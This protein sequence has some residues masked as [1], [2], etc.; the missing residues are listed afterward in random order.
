MKKHFITG[1][2]IL[3]PGV[4]TLLVLL[5]LIDFLTKPFIGFATDCFIRWDLIPHGFGFFTQQQIIEYL[6]RILIL[7][8][9]FAATILLGA[10]A[11]W[12]FMHWVIK[13]CD[14][15]LLKIPLVSTIYKATQDIIKTLF[16]SDKN[17][18]KQ[19]VMVPF[20]RPGVYVLGLV[21]RE[22]PM[23]C[24]EATKENLIS[25]LVPTTPNPTTGFLLMF[26]KKDLIYLDMKTEDAIKYV[27]SCGVIIPENQPP[28]SQ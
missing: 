22:S 26:P 15:V 4:L 9:L 2:I 20:P 14:K 6:S 18:F 16:S 17:S 3:L 7:L 28:S 5:F 1:L 21:A 24:Q 19:V 27:V 25:V 12:F 23:Q 11:R 13:I 8:F 10:L